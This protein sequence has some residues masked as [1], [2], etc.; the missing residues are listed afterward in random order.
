MFVACNTLCFAQEPMETALRHILELEFDKFELSLVEGGQ[1]L[2]L[3]E[4]GDDPDGALTQIRRG[5]S[6]APSALFLDAAAAD[7]SA[8]A[9][10]DTSKRF[11]GLCRLA[12]SLSVAVI[13]MQAAPRG[14]SVDEEVKRLNSLGSDAFRKGLVLALLTH[15]ETLTGDPEVAV[16]LCRS[17]PGLGITLDPS[18]YLQGPNPEVDFDGVFP[19]VQNVHLR[20]TGTA[21]GEFQVRVGQGK[22]DYARIVNMLQR[23]GYNRSLTVSI[24]DRPDNPFDRE[25]EVRKLKLLLETLI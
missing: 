14:T 5:P 17:V 13:T 16:E 15:S 19:Y 9:G 7:W 1:H 18:H 20:D 10:A 4:A 6:L 22:I 25:V 24:M 21:P 8:P 23:H 3:S 11:E 12:K 2:R